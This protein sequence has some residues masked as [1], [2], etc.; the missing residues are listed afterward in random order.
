MSTATAERP[1]K[2]KR[3][4]IARPG[5]PESKTPMKFRLLDGRHYHQEADEDEPQEYTRG[6]VIETTKDLCALNG[7]PPMRPKFE[8]VDG[9]QADRF[10]AAV[11][12]EVRRRLQL[13]GVTEELPDEPQ[14]EEVAKQVS[15]A[16]LRKMSLEQLESYA[17]EEEIELG[18]EV[19]EKA[20]IIDAILAHN[21]RKVE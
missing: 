11:Q 16:S 18:D 3:R 10:E 12:A 19:T 1:A 7:P 14:S 17:A 21:A 8:R 4:A 6:Q 13:A 2:K 5:L 9:P 20:G 15:L